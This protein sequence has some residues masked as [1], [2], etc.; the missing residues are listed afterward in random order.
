M[1]RVKQD[2]QL[3]T[4][5]YKFKFKCLLDFT[6]FAV[7]KKYENLPIDIHL[8]GETDMVRKPYDLRIQDYECEEDEVEEIE[9]GS[10]KKKAK[11]NWIIK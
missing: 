1:V 5:I 2:Q 7:G 9:S 3:F 10:P 8:C 6:S 4:A 11:F